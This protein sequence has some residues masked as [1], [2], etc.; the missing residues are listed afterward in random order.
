MSSLDNLKHLY[1]AI[2]HLLTYFIKITFIELINFCIITLAL[3]HNPT[4]K[5]DR[6]HRVNYPDWS[7]AFNISNNADD[8][9]TNTYN[10]ADNA[11]QIANNTADIATNADE[12]ADNTLDITPV[13][14]G[15]K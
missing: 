2:L 4:N 10:I 12:I 3:S 15:L 7:A 14:S 1:E 11:A 8:I 6:F 13:S 5:T 9:M